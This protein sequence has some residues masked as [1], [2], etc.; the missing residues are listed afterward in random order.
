V[1]HQHTVESDLEV[2]YNVDEEVGDDFVDDYYE[3]GDYF[4]D[5]HEGDDIAFS[6]IR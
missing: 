3:V 2:I 4:N 6:C 1:W 5:D